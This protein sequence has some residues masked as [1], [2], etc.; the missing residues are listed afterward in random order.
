MGRIPG[1][2]WVR[3]GTDWRIAECYNDGDWALFGYA[4]Y[5]EES[6]FDEIDENRI[7]REE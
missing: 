7:V 5:Y 3:R 1:F 4:C 2:Y 6:A